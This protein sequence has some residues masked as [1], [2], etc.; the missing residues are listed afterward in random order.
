MG[1]LPTYG[2]KIVDLLDWNQS[3]IGEHKSDDGSLRLS[4]DQGKPFRELWPILYNFVPMR[5]LW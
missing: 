3:Q 4:V 2:G 1:Y 5:R